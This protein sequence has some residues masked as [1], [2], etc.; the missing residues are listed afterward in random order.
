MSVKEWPEPTAF[1]VCPAP[2]GDARRGHRL[3]MGASTIQWAGRSTATTVREDRLGHRRAPGD[4]DRLPRSNDLDRYRTH[5][6]LVHRHRRPGRDLHPLH[7]L[8]PGP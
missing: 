6:R 8:G 4:D 5:R 1:T 7:L 3:G 2:A